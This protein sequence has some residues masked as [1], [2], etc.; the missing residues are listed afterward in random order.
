MGMFTNKLKWL[1]TLLIVMLL[2][3]SACA[4]GDSADL[5]DDNEG[6]DFVIGMEIDASSLDPAGSNDVPSHKVE[7]FIYDKLVARDL[8]GNLIPGIAE[9]WDSVGDG[10]YEFKLREGVKFHDGEDFNADVVKKNIERLLDPDVASSVYDKFEMITDVQVVDEYTV[11]IKTAYPFTPI[12]GHFAHPGSGMISPILIDEDYEAMANGK[13]AGTVISANPIGTGSYKFESWTSGEEIKLVRNEEYWGDKSLVDAITFKVI[14]ESGTRI[15]DLARGFIHI[16]DPIQPN[17]VEEINE[18]DYA[19]VMQTSS[20]GMAFIG[21][22]TEKEPFNDVRVRKAV[23][24]MINKDE[25]IEGVYEGFGIAASGPLAPKIFGFSEDVQAPQYNV[26][27]A[28]KLLAEAG[29]SDGFSAEIWTN[30]NQQRIDAAIILQDALKEVNIDLKIEQMEFGAYLE[31]LT[32][33]NH[34]MY[35]LGWNPSLPDGDNGL[36]QLFHSSGKGKTPNV[37]FYGNDEVDHLLDEGRR[38]SDQDK[39]FNLYVEAQEKIVE[40]APM[41]YMIYQENLT[42][43]SNKVLGLEI[44]STGMYHLKD[45]KITD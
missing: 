30:D 11:Q 29:Y 24:M 9:S 16:A 37:M 2:L 12:F 19:K 34:D 22:N 41:I 23:S 10:I 18:S 35:I 40:D 39:R 8:E 33:G 20:N 43:V 27:E 26:E 6:K 13:K 1:G 15:A 14:P 25:I 32:K 42:G 21:F 28:K 44:D 45:V 7:H 3:L 31:N 38:E 4:N 36:Y 17:E 5:D